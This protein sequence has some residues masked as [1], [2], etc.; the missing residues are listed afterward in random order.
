[1]H[2]RERDVEKYLVERLESVGLKCIK[3]L[4]DMLNG[5]PDRLVLLPGGRVVWVELKTRGGELSELQKLRG[6]EL[7]RAGHEVVVVWTKEQ[8]DELAWRL[9]RGES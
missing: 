6:L 3:F 1:M 9:S 8:A 5:M 2:V 4:P 7:R